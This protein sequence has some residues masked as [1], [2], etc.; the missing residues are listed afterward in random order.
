MPELGGVAAGA[1][2]SSDSAA[3][4]AK[5]GL[6]GA[7]SVPAPESGRERKVATMVFA[8]LVGFTSLNESADPELVQALVTRAFDRLSTEVVRYE[9]M[10]EKFA[11]DAMLAVF[12]VPA[13]HEDDA[14]R[15][16]RAAL[17]MQAAMVELAAEL[18]RE[19]HPELSLR[20]GIETG[21]VLVDLGRASGERDRIVTGDAV[22]TAARLQQV[23][24]PGAI[25]VGPFTYAATRDVV[26]YE[27]LPAAVL[28]GKALPVAAWRAVAV[29][30]RRGGVRPSLGI[31]APLI[32]R[33]EE[34]ALVKETVRRTVS[35]RR[36]HLVTI[37]G[38]AGVGK[39][40][41]TWELEKYLDG[42]P[43]V[44]YWRKGRC[45]AYAQASYSA[46]ADAV[47][48][49]AKILDDDA[50]ATAQAKLGARVAELGCADDPSIAN[51]LAALLALGSNE[52]IGRDALYDA[53]RRY[54]EALAGRQ[55]ADP[56]PGGHPL[57]R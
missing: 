11:G 51:A 9:G 8:D 43:D 6:G 53:W 54:L 28:K 32:G 57:G 4:A 20:I 22:N 12:G 42:L 18:R 10:V 52:G 16:V 50:P 3:P 29:K 33:D 26:E 15:A 56:R 45:L 21:E 37:I 47:K 7:A 41:L 48:A 2:P 24:P 19:G 23:A 14:E 5:G 46:L 17:E 34:I 1:P 44:F 35:E 25:V 36:P 39:S 38:S 30:A 55:P 27:E 13:I 40:R 31:E 49:D